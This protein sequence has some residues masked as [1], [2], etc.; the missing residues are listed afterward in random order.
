MTTYL[1]TYPT[2][3]Q[4][5]RLADAIV[6][7][8]RFQLMESWQDEL[9][10]SAR[11]LGLAQISPVRVLKGEIGESAV[12]MLVSSDPEGATW[13]GS[14][15]RDGTVTLLQRD[16]GDEHYIPLFGSVFGLDGDTVLLPTGLIDDREQPG[17]PLT[18]DE[19]VDLVE[20]EIAQVAESR[21]LFVQY[22]PAVADATETRT[23]VEL[24]GEADLPPHYPDGERATGPHH[25]E[26]DAPPEGAA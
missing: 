21:D 10:D 15:N 3:R 17:R 6:V 9:E 26:P 19:L 4:Q 24:A 5:I 16:A 11:T 12:V 14:D 13:P 18:L 7:T 22:E 20:A 2:L 1:S 25:A 8:E 23:V